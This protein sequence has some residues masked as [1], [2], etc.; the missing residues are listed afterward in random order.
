MNPNSL[1]ATVAAWAEPALAV[2]G[3]LTIIGAILSWS[4][5]WRIANLQVGRRAYRARRVMHLWLKDHPAF[6]DL[7]DT[8]VFDDVT[9]VGVSASLASWQQ[10]ATD[11][12]NEVQALLEEMVDLAGEAGPLVRRATRK[13]YLY[14]MKGSDRLHETPPRGQPLEWQTQLRAAKEHFAAAYRELGRAGPNALLSPTA[15]KPTESP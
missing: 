9:V 2:L 10:T 4:E 14:F 11:S 13:A 5:R 8:E 7:G 3:I 15:I 6:R 1:A 12:E